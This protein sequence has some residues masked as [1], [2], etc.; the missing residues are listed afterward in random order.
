MELAEWEQATVFRVYTAVALS[1][2][3]PLILIW[4]KRLD[5]WAIRAA[6]IGFALCA[7]GW[8]IWF[9]F[10]LVDGLPV[11]ARRSP[12]LNAAIPQNI[13]WLMNSVA[14]MGIC[15]MGLLFAWLAAG[16]NQA[17]AFGQWHWGAFIAMTTWFI[18]QNVYVEAVVYQR[19]LAEGFDLS[20]APL[21][22]T[23]PYLNPS[24]ALGDSTLTLH[25]QIPWLIMPVLYYWLVIKSYR[26]WA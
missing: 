16:R 24:M 6:L 14:D 20:W 26:K 9:T 11:D 10:G 13:N 8:E 7:L 25:G 18:A 12:A 17:R 5:G 2:L 4:C 22:P 21:A 1:L 15:F 3:V 23:G 19:Q